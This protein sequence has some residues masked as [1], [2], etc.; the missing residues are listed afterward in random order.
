MKTIDNVKTRYDSEVKL[1]Y[2]M[3]QLRFDWQDKA[4]Q[5]RARRWLELNNKMKKPNYKR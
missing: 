1:A 4:A 5:L 3:E 2:W